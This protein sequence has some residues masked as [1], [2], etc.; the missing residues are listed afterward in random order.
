MKRRTRTALAWGCF[1][2]WLACIL[3]AIAFRSGGQVHAAVVMGL[4]SLPWLVGAIK[5]GEI[6]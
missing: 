6:E 2:A 3:C 5:W 4:A 1:G